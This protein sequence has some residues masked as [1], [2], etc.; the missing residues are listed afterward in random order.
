MRDFFKGIAVITAAL[1]LVPLFL[2][3]AEVFTPKP[4]TIPA[5]SELPPENTAYALIREV[6][7]YD[8]VK[9]TAF[10][11]S[12]EDFLQSA[13][14]AQLTETAPKEAIKA[15]ATLMYTYILSQRLNQLANPTP[16][17]FGADISTD[18]SKYPALVLDKEAPIA[19][20]TA[21]SEVLGDYIAYNGEPIQAAYCVSSGGYTESALT[22]LGEDIP[23]LQSVKCDFDADYVTEVLYTSDE[24]FARITTSCQGVTLYGE[25]NEWITKLSASSGGY[26]TEVTLCN[27]HHIKGTL[28][29]SALN[30]PSAN[31]TYKYSSEFDRF[32]FTVRGCGHLVGLSLNG[33]CEMAKQNKTCEE[34][35][36][37][38]FTGIEIIHSQTD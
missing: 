12:T 22:V 8:T 24:L 16:A 29:A 10:T 6:V 14:M 1:I 36:K 25:P 33:A 27:D 21:V 4:Q 13:L 9:Q 7:V 11:L 18:S 34:I 19:F 28:F 31:F 20:K 15:Q 35:L 17:L 26:V 2:L 23:Y 5:V 38:F 3:L 30:L 32:T 37:H